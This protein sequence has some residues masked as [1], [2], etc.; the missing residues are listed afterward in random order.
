M[1]HGQPSA[2]EQ[3]REE[4]MAQFPT[5]TTLDESQMEFMLDGRIAKL[6]VVLSRYRRQR[7]RELKRLL[8]EAAEKGLVAQ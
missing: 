8:K 5:A 7:K 1:S 2:V 4:F 3:L 6:E